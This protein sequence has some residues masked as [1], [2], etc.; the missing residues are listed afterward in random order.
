MRKETNLFLKKAKLDERW[1]FKTTKKGKINMSLH[2]Y[3]WP[4]CSCHEPLS[5]YCF[6]IIQLQLNNKWECLYS[7]AIQPTISDCFALICCSGD[8]PRKILGNHMFLVNNVV[9]MHVRLSV[10]DSGHNPQTSTHACNSARFREVVFLQVNHVNSAAAR[11]Y[12][13]N[14]NEIIAELF[15]G[16]FTHWI[17]M[18]SCTWAAV[19]HDKHEHKLF[20]F[21]LIIRQNL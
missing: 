6:H 8:Y 15:Q 10:T 5:Q 19:A 7:E 4:I 3:K 12:Q 17:K 16:M 14:P 18:W 20:F 21:L 2:H 9:T 13:S 1:I 11:W